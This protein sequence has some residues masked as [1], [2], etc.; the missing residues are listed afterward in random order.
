MLRCRRPPREFPSCCMDDE[1]IKEW[2]WKYVGNV[3]CYKNVESSVDDWTCGMP[4]ISN[5]PSIQGHVPWSWK[6]LRSDFFHWYSSHSHMR[7]HTRFISNQKHPL[8]VNHLL[9][10]FSDSDEGRPGF[11]A[12]AEKVCS[13]MHATSESEDG[14]RR[15]RENDRSNLNFPDFRVYTKFVT[16][17]V[18]YGSL[19]KLRSDSYW[20]RYS[21][22]IMQCHCYLWHCLIRLFR[23]ERDSLDSALGR[24]RRFVLHHGLGQGAIHI[25]CPSPYKRGMWSECTDKLYINFA[26]R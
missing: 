26:N 18:K 10:I 23:S 6:W 25:W 17:S 21:C 24:L 12:L 1:L 22:Q 19:E 4:S 2:R 20:L 11:N 7:G 14:D 5:Y 3:E 13:R 9:L 15:K 16:F 8:T